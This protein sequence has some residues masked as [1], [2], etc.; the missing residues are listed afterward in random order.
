M[1]T[2]PGLNVQGW[3]LPGAEAC[4]RYTLEER[5][6][7]TGVCLCAC[8]RAC[9]QVKVVLNFWVQMREH[10]PGVKSGWTGRGVVPKKNKTDLGSHTCALSGWGMMR[11]TDKDRPVD[12]RQRQKKRILVSCWLEPFLDRAGAEGFAGG[13]DPVRTRVPPSSPHLLGP[14]VDTR[15][16]WRY[17]GQA[18]LPTGNG[19]HQTR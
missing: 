9:R 12:S 2:R 17:Y 8:V 5:V 18:S 16:A 13:G 10:G 11:R 7:I 4:R 3:T 6:D 19:V 15:K 1:G 14:T